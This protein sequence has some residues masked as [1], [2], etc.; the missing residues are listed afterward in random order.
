MMK[1]TLYGVVILCIT[2]LC[3][4]LLTRDRLCAVRVQQGDTLVA[5]TLAYEARK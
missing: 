2:V 3:V 5:V 1:N 4:I